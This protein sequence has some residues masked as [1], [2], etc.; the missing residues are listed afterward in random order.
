MLNQSKVQARNE[1]FF[2]TLTE[3]E[4]ITDPES[5]IRLNVYYQHPGILTSQINKDFRVSA[6]SSD[7][8]IS[9]SNKVIKRKTTELGTVDLY[10]QLADL[11]NCLK[12]EI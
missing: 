7:K 3:D 4:R 10:N 11:K 8:L 9:L 2:D 1:A 6:S 5:S 12:S